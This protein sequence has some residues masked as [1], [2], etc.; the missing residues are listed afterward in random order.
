MG[1]SDSTLYRSQFI[2]NYPYLSNESTVA[3]IPI[4]GTN[5]NIQEYK[6]FRFFPAGELQK[7]FVNI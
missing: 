4:L 6:Y 2:S 1:Y 5:N 7:A 3:R